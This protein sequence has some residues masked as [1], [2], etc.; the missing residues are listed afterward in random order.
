M[1]KDWGILPEGTPVKLYTLTNAIGMQLIVS[2]Y[3]ATIISIIIS[4]KDK[5]YD[6]VL[7]FDTV[8]D[9]IKSRSIPAHPY[10]GAVI[11][12]YAGRIKKGSFIL[13]DVRYT[14]PINNGEN[15]LHGGIKGFDSVV[16]QRK[17][18]EAENTNS[19]TLSY[20]SRAGEEN[21]PGELSV[22][23][24]YTLTEE[25]AVEINYTANTSED[26]IINLTQHTY[27]NLDGHT[28]NINEQ[29][30]QLPT[31]DLLEIDEANIPSGRIIKA[32]VKGF[33]FTEERPCPVGIDDS[34]ILTGN[35]VPAATLRNIKTG[36]TLNVFTDQP[37]VH[38]Y[39]GGNCFGE[40]E[41]K[42]GAA[43]HTRSGICFETQ[44]YPDSPNHPEFPNTVLRKHDTYRQTTIWKF[45]TEQ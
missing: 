36:L 6:V 35:F 16:W 23:V 14:L 19:L 9:Y 13:N 25:N 44:H 4:V 15:T 20:T 3:G 34:F 40:V 5:I 33:D 11:G 28:S 12:R 42:G 43:Y 29:M 27:F 22:E 10:F 21:F 7:G 30:L 39:T 17:F 41:G 31:G 37:S 8:E 24:T 1:Q 2:D 38:I 26:T 45:T 18:I 32:A